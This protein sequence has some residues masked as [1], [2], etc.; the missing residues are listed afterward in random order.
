MFHW[1]CN[2]VIRLWLRKRNTFFVINSN[3]SIDWLIVSV[4]N[5]QLREMLKMCIPSWNNKQQNS[6]CQWYFKVLKIWVWQHNLQIINSSF[7]FAFSFTPAVFLLLFHFSFFLYSSLSLSV[8]V[9]HPSFVLAVCSYI[10]HV[11]LTK[12]KK[13]QERTHK[14]KLSRQQNYMRNERGRQRKRVNKERAVKQGDNTWG[15]K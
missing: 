8:L 12:K 9:F 1:L 10:L 7:S 3:R 2:A 13:K 15:K 14:D 4:T 6:I 5:D 11:W